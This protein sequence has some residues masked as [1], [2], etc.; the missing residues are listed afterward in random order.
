MEKNNDKCGVCRKI[1]PKNE[2]IPPIIMKKIGNYINEIDKIKEKEIRDVCIMHKEKI[3]FFCMKCLKKYCGKC[4]FFGSEEAKKHEGHNIIDYDE[5]VKSDYF[6][7]INEVNKYQESQKKDKEIIEKNNTYKEE[8]DIIYN[9]GKFIFDEFQKMFDDK[10]K[11]KYY[12]F[13][14]QSREL[15]LAKGNLDKKYNE[16]IDNLTKLENINKKIENFDPKIAE[17]EITSNMNLIN[18]IRQQK[19]KFEININF[20]LKNFVKIFTYQE[21]IKEKFVLINY[22]YLTSI[23]LIKEGDKELLE[24]K[25]ENRNKP[26]FILFLYINFNNKIYNFKKI[27]KGEE[28]NK[29]INSSNFNNANKKSE[30]EKLSNN[31]SNNIINQI[32]ESEKEK[33]NDEQKQ[34]EKKE[35]KMQKIINIDNNKNTKKEFVYITFIP[36]NEL[37]ETN[38]NIFN[39]SY[40]EFFVK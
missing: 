37:N 5:L 2:I 35:E 4:L 27:E 22:P 26:P 15:K 29:N 18:N 39:F 28:E 36:K 21:I 7:I 24:F 33:G 31:N 6:N 9:K 25:V 16:I 8:I 20:C 3:L 12:F 13:N 19:P 38:N 14:K 11:E 1:I 23:K 34:E 40:Y 10:L 30:S 32:V 17:K